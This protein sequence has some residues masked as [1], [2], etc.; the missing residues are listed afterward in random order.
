DLRDALLDETELG[1]PAGQD[2]AHGRPSAVTELGVNGAVERLQA[3][4]REAVASIP[5][6]PGEDR[7]KAL[8]MAQAARLAPSGLETV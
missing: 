1:K 2:E 4:L 3:L 7:L 6:C 5:E 8:V